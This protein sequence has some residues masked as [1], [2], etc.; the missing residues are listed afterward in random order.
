MV[1]FRSIVPGFPMPMY[2][3]QPL[4][5]NDCKNFLQTREPLARSIEP[6]TSV[7]EYAEEKPTNACWSHSNQVTFSWNGCRAS[8]LVERLKIATQT[9][10]LLWRR[11]T[12]VWRKILKQAVFIANINFWTEHNLASTFIIRYFTLICLSLC[13]WKA[14]INYFLPRFKCSCVNLL[15]ILRLS[16]LHIT[17]YYIHTLY[18]SPRTSIWSS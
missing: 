6:S 14:S 5:L 17:F 8:F 7:S 3:L 11:N 16:L 1:I 15:I 18:R 13:G 2:Y 9:Y 12:T 4:I 10:Q